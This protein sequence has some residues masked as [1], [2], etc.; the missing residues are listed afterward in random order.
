MKPGRRRMRRRA[1]CLPRDNVAVVMQ[2]HC[3]VVTH[4]GVAEPSE[5]AAAVWAV[6]EPLDRS[7]VLAPKISSAAVTP[8][9]PACVAWQIGSKH[10]LCLHPDSRGQAAAQQEVLS[11]RGLQALA[12]F[13]TVRGVQP[14]RAPSMQLPLL[15]VLCKMDVRQQRTIALHWQP[16][17]GVR[18]RRYILSA[19]LCSM[20]QPPVTY[21]LQLAEEHCL[22]DCHRSHAALQQ[23]RQAVHLAMV[24]V[25]FCH[26]YNI[27]LLVAK[28]I[29]ALQGAA[30]MQ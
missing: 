12:S 11:R 7:D 20:S 30:P 4:N 26:D 23:C 24:A 17:P 3:H 21:I 18:R 9:W 28:A 10:T 22:K 27:I 29:Q 15:D 2:R 8:P 6:H 25:S 19:C 16:Q 1:S 14:S 13:I 5:I